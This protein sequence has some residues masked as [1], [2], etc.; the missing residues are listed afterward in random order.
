MEVFLLMLAVIVIWIFSG[1]SGTGNKR[2]DRSSVSQQRV[3]GAKTH[4]SSAPT[5]QVEIKSSISGGDSSD[6]WEAEKLRA[7][8]TAFD[9]IVRQIEVGE[10]IK[11][12]LWREYRK[13]ES[14]SDLYRIFEITLGDTEWQWPWLERCRQRFA[15]T[16]ETISAYI[17]SVY[18]GPPKPAENAPELAQLLSVAQMRDWLKENKR[19]PK[20][21]PR[22]REEFAAL[23]SAQPWPDLK[24][25]AQQHFEANKEQ[26]D[27]QYEKARIEMLVN[28]LNCRA[29]AEQSFRRHCSLGRVM[30]IRAQSAPFAAEQAL[31]FSRTQ[32]EPLPPFFPGDNSRLT[33]VDQSVREEANKRL[34]DAVLKPGEDPSEFAVRAYKAHWINASRAADGNDYPMAR[35]WFAK[36]GMALHGLPGRE[37]EKQQLKDEAALALA[38][39]PAYMLALYKIKKLIA[40][41]PG[42]L[43]KDIYD[44]LDYSREDT[45]QVLYFAAENRE[46]V[47]TKAGSTYELSLPSV[48]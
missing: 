41:T 27:R 13:N 46:I 44:K 1:S 40:E 39:D 42:I 2:K 22:K 24:P 43:Q 33:Y 3:R 20:P 45:Q 29:W 7:K 4:L 18:R 5:I 10:D 38:K 32:L 36:A 30:T 26:L 35:K 19:Y 12:S 11:E 48:E 34:A 15:S 23:I 9:A 6:S 25:L 16:Q 17:A 14:S 47:R 28:T 21:A 31:R 37:E 8:R